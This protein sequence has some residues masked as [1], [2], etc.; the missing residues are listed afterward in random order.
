MRRAGVPLQDGF[1]AKTKLVPDWSEIENQL[2]EDFEKIEAEARRKTGTEGNDRGQGSKLG[3]GLRWDV[4]RRTYD[5]MIDERGGGVRTSTIRAFK[6]Q[7]TGFIVAPVDK[8][9][10]EMA[11]L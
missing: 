10:Q 9:T 8:Y 1:N 7:T 6:S 3:G 2:M 5:R 11:I 4:L